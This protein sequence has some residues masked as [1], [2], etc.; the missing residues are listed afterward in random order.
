M[1]ANI[2]R[3]GV[4]RS[5]VGSLGT[6]WFVGDRGVWIWGLGGTVGGVLLVVSIVLLMGSNWGL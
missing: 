5:A 4:S 6:G 3:R 2:F 1:A